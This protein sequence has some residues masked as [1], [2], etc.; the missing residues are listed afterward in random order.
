MF[1]GKGFKV[2][3]LNVR[4]LWPNIDEVRVHFA[5]FDVRV[6]VKLG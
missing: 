4:S 3:M 5:E 2:G 1:L 6:F